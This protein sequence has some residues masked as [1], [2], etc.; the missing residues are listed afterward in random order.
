MTFIC[1]FICSRLVFLCSKNRPSCYKMYWC[2]YLRK[3]KEQ[4]SSREWAVVSLVPL[5]PFVILSCKYQNLKQAMVLYFIKS[6]DII[7]FDEQLWHLASRSHDTANTR[8]RREWRPVCEK[9]PA[10]FSSPGWF[11][12]VFFRFRVFVVLF[13]FLSD[14]CHVWW[15]DQTS[16]E[17]VGSTEDRWGPFIVF[18]DQHHQQLGASPSARVAAV[19]VATVAVAVARHRF[20][21]TEEMEKIKTKILRNVNRSNS[22]GRYTSLQKLDK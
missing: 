15:P 5:V 18:M 14:H 6:L 2:V 9:S 20:D 8:I 7:R 13:F 11:H 3:R 17:Q 1:S 22:N 19:Y 10:S 16:H 4:P 12:P 21:W